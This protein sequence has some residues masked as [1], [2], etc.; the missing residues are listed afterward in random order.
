M[1]WG[2]SAGAQISGLLS[3]CMIN[4]KAGAPPFHDLLPR[5]LVE[6][7][8]FFFDFFLVTVLVFP[9]QSLGLNS[10]ERAEANCSPLSL[11][12][13]R[14]SVAMLHLCFLH[15]PS[16]H[17]FPQC[18]HYSPSCITAT[19]YVPS[20]LVHRLWCVWHF[21]CLQQDLFCRPFLLPGVSSL[22]SSVWLTLIHYSCLS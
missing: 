22:G 11:P 2:Y 15:S 19:A 5:P 7:T 9:S 14:Q 16:F 6:A 17:Q 3:S 20:L 1:R 13:P 10:L 12:Y 4:T 21:S 18:T 8:A